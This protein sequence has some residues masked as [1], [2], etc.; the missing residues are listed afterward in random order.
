M[1]R[2]LAEEGAAVKSLDVQ[3]VIDEQ[4][5]S[6]VHIVLLAL[7]AV[8]MFFDGFDIF[9]VG[10]VAPAIAHSYG[11]PSTQLT[12]VFVLQQI[13]LTAGAFL[14]SPLSDRYGR[15]TVL[16]WSIIAFA[17]F[18]LLTIWAQSL[19]QVAILRGLT[20]IFLAAVIPNAT[21][22]LTEFA[23]AHRRASFVAIA[24]TGYTAGGAAGAFVAMWL[25]DAYGW[26]SGFWI[27]GLLPL[28]IVPLLFFFTHESVQ[29]RARR[30]PADPKIARTLKRLRPDLDFTG[31]T[32]FTLGST[33]KKSKGGV[34]QVFRDGRAPLTILLWS[35]Y[36]MALG[37]ITLLAS[38]MATFFNELGG[39]SLA[40]YAAVSLISFVGGL[41]GT[42][43]VGFIMDRFAPVRVLT[44]L[45]LIDAIGLALIGMLPF[46]GIAS[47]IAFTVWGYCQAGG[48]AGINALCAQAYPPS[49]RSTGVGWAFGMGRFGGVFA[50]VLGGIALSMSLALHEAFLLAAVLPLTI[51]AL[52]FLFER[53]IL[54]DPKRRAAMSQ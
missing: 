49:I 31:I 1:S 30:N 6:G 51:I 42:M 16:I 46:G 9:M 33:A 50:P 7:C 39:I 40:R 11:E 38:W 41:A 19:L 8:I 22:L 29:F 37:T 36:F 5:V 18:T 47:L 52:L 21:A 13:G 3:T 44:I 32:H 45:F 53:L 10:K 28:L 23:P 34:W 26:Q 43:T 15:K 20:G 54:R 35:I 24:F 25:L 14:I 2:P 17:V 4:K 12:M 27:G 48:Q